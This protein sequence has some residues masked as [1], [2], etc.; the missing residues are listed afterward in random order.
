MPDSHDDDI[1]QSIDRMFEEL[2]VE[3]ETNRLGVVNVRNSGAIVSMRRARV[4]ESVYLMHIRTDRN[5]QGRG[6]ASELLAEICK[7]ADRNGVC[8]FL[9]VEK[10]DNGNLSESQL[11]DWYWRLGF[12]GEREEMVREPQTK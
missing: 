5:Q 9:E 2:E 7:A 11:L 4:G 8:L 6:H 1:E 10:G 12:R 3:H